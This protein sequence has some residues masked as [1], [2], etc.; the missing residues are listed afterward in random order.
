[1]CCLSVVM[2]GGGLDLIVVSLPTGE[3]VDAAS[4]G[5]PLLELSWIKTDHDVKRK[6]LGHCTISAGGKKS[7]K[8]P[9]SV[10][11]ASNR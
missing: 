2:G 6:G 7:Y 10:S 4:K 3:S 5:C 8:E 9:E 11:D 1:M